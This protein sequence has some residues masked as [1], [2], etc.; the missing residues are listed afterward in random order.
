M[1]R[2]TSR[3]FLI[4]FFWK[5]GEKAFPLLNRPKQIWSKGMQVPQVPTEGSSQ[6]V[7]TEPP[8]P[9][10]R[11]GHWS[12]CAM[13]QS[14]KWCLLDAWTQPCLRAGGPGQAALNKAEAFIVQ[15]DMALDKGEPPGRRSDND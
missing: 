6:Q 12:A 13:Q 8:V 10:C 2:I 11:A 7:F 9:G 15:R 4:F 14:K 1:G 3:S 5:Q